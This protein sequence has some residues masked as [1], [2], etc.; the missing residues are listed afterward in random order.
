[1]AVLLIQRRK[2]QGGLDFGIPEA[3]YVLENGRVRDVRNRERLFSHRLIEAFMVEANESVA[4]FLKQRKAPMLYRVH[5]APQWERLHSLLQSLVK[6]PCQP[7]LPLP[8]LKKKKASPP[9]SW[10]PPLLRAAEDQDCAWLVNTLV[11]RTMMQARYDPE[12]DIHFGLASACYCHFTSPIRRYADLMVHRALRHSLGLDTGGTVPGAKKLLDVAE[13]CNTRERVAQS[14]EREI[15]RRMGCLVLQ[16]REGDEFQ[17]IISGVTGFGLF[18]Q[19]EGKPLEGLVR[20][21]KLGDD[22]FHYHQDRQELRGARSRQAFRLGD[23][24]MVRLSDVNVDRLEIN[25][26]LVQPLQGYKKKRRK[27]KGKRLDMDTD[28]EQA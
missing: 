10:L 26:N 8:S 15:A 2:T 17:G 21:E 12:P 18:V 28:F 9:Q 6:L 16:G 20:I 11:L 19:L 1:L 25:L 4:R 23:S 22:Y 7:P 27:K 5:P 14:A 13:I 3:E 24:L